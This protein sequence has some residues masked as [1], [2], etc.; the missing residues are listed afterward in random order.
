MFNPGALLRS[1]PARPRD[2]PFYRPPSDVNALPPGALIRS[3]VVRLGFLGVLPQPNMSAWQLAYRS[4]DLHGRAEVA[5]TTVIVPKQQMPSAPKRLVAYQ[6]AIDAVSDR[7]FPSYGLRLGAVVPGALP[8]LELTQIGFLLERGFVV[9][10]ADHEGLG[11]VF[12]APREPG[13]RVLDGIRATLAFDPV[14][15]ATDTEVGLFGYSGGGMASA[16][17]AEMAPSYAPEIHLVGAVLGSP[18]GDPGEAFLKLNRTLFAGLPALV[19]AGLAKVYPEI[20]RVIDEHASVDGR[21]R[22]KELE[23]LTTAGAVIAYRH[24]DFDDFLDSPLADVLA[25]PEVLD[26]IADLRLGERI[27]ECPLLVVQAVHDRII[28]VLDVDAQVERYVEGGATVRYVRERFSEHIGLMLIA[29]PLMISWLEAR[30]SSA[31]TA[32]GTAHVRSLLLSPASWS[33]YADLVGA[34]L[35][36]VLGRGGATRT[37]PMDEVDESGNVIG[38]H[39]VRIGHRQRDVRTSG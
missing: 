24:D 28:D 14:Q 3:R 18:V 5:V 34:T 30:F 10:V 26:V 1:R 11:G 13:H 37:D 27:P 29:Q 31:P 16:W 12:G 7:C 36:L 25:L 35:R 4:T 38:M 23:D 19:I 32:T 6:C 22:L 2:D 20:S 8:P 33:G 17:A 15:L 21:R 39:D 9:S